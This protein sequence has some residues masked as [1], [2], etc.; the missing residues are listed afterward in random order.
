MLW[1]PWTH[2]SPHRSKYHSRSSFPN[3]STPT[4]NPLKKPLSA[5]IITI[6]AKALTANNIITHYNKIKGNLP[7]LASL[8]GLHSI[9]FVVSEDSAPHPLY[10]L[11]YPHH[12]QYTSITIQIQQTQPTNQLKHTTTY[13]TFVIYISTK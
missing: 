10:N 6:T 13:I 12:Q 2:N 3:H 7:T 9:P 4:R 8:N 5:L 11:W 1:L